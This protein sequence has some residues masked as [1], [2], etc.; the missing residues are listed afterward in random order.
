MIDFI[1]LSL[2]KILLDSINTFKLL[3][4]IFYFLKYFSIWFLVNKF[5]LILFYNKKSITKFFYFE[6]LFRWGQIRVIDFHQRVREQKR[7][8]IVYYKNIRY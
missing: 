6:S 3:I 2:S 4:V 7:K 1:R 8:L 5:E